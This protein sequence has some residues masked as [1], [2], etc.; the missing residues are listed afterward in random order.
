MVST[1]DKPERFNL[2]SKNSEMP[3]DQQDSNLVVSHPEQQDTEARQDSAEGQTDIE[4]PMDLHHSMVAPALEE[5]EC[6][7]K[8]STRMHRLEESQARRRRTMLSKYWSTRVKSIDSRRI[9]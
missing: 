1:V 4:R 3:E 2:L 9:L 6:K 7:C 8:P 5:I